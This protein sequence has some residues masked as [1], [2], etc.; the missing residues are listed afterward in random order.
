[1]LTKTENGVE[2]PAAAYAYVG[3]PEKTD[4]WKLRLWESPET[5]VTVAQLGR[6]AAAFSAGGFRGNKVEIPSADVAGVKAKI[7]AE[8]KKL[9]VKP[10]DIPDSLAASDFPHFVVLL[11]SVPETGLV[12]IPIAK[13]GTWY[14]GGKKFVITAADLQSVVSHFRA[15]ANGEVAGD[16][17]HGSVFN[18]GSGDP[19][20]ACGWL[21]AIDDAPDSGGVLWGDV[22]FTEKARQ[23]IAAKEYKYISPVIAWG[24]K[25]KATGQPTGAMLTSWA[26]TNAP[27]LDQMPAIAMSEGWV[28]ESATGEETIMVKKLVLADRAAG[29][30]RAIHED[31]TETLHAVEG[32]EAQPKVLHASELQRNQDGCI[33]LA[34]LDNLP[35]GTL[36]G[37]DVLHALNVQR[38]LDAAIQSGKI[39]PAQ[40]AF[41]EKSAANDLAGFRQLVASLKPQV[42]TT[43]RGVAG[44]GTEAL[45]P[46]DRLAALA[47][48]KM[49]A[50]QGMQYSEA[51]RLV[52]TENPELAKEWRAQRQRR[53]GSEGK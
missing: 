17:E 11:A 26:L 52:A 44:T 49:V 29:T 4:T 53:S 22:D 35:A 40:R 6:A 33:N 15:K 48:A 27:L 21:K 30:A 32:L 39:L 12:R 3:D 18:A 19:I 37:F 45:S 7:R 10:E 16:Y 47:E 14:K 20:P 13:L 41:Y 36:I 51:L 31:G 42:D 2:F 28:A 50:T 1:M 25:D 46:G 34:A 43:E 9:G 5:K 24:A 38:E 8:Y 23:M